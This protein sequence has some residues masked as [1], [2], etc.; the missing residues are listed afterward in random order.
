MFVLLTESLLL[1]NE[2]NNVPKMFQIRLM[3]V[4][5]APEC[6]K[7]L[8][9]HPAISRCDTV[10]HFADKGKLPWLRALQN[11]TNPSLQRS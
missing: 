4:E 5:S 11:T 7:A 10:R 6:S 2:E 3:H 8:I 1:S 9:A